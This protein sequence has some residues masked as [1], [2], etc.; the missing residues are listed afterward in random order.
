MKKIFNFQFSI[1][2]KLQGQVMLAVVIFFLGF[3]LALILG[4]ALPILRGS[5]S[6]GDLRDSKQA[7]YASESLAEDIAYRLIVGKQVSTAET[8]PVASSTA[9]SSSSAI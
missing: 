2:K 4:F 8:L 5:Q 3:S 9:T 1:F 7:F 6:A